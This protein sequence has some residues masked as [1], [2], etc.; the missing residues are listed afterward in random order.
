MKESVS[1]FKQNFSS[2]AFFCIM[3]LDEMRDNK[4]H[5]RN[6]LLKKGKRRKKR[7]SKNSSRN[8]C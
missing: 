5:K 1:S 2:L 6:G 8:K 3:K 7:K 4:W